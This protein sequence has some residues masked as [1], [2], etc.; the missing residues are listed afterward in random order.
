MA[1]AQLTEQEIAEMRSQRSTPKVADQEA[2]RKKLAAWFARRIEAEGGGE[3]AI[4]SLQVP[5][6]AGMSN[7]TLLFEL[8]WRDADGAQRQRRCVARLQP[9]GQRVVFP[10]YDMSIQYRLM[11]G[12][13]GRVPVPLL[14]GLEEDAAVIGQPFYVMEHVDGLVPPDIPPMHMAGWVRDDTTPAER[15]HMWWIALEAM[16]K[17]HAVSWREDGF[18]FLFARSPGETAQQQ[19]FSYWEHYMRW[20]PEDVP[21]PE[22]ERAFEWFVANNPPDDEEHTGL[23]WGDARLG[24]TMYTPDRREVAAVLD[25]EM[26]MIGDPVQDL[27]WWLFLDRSMSE[28]LG[29][30]RLEGFPGERESIDYW[31]RET[32]RDSSACKYYQAF[33]AFN[34]GLIMIRT[35]LC[36]G[37][38]PLATNFVTP[39]MEKTLAELKG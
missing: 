1:E 12:L 28:G 4:S 34:F 11:D 33:T 20:A 7:I 19:L 36:G 24:N 10:D 14:L 13:K 9:V 2:T 37:M 16:A 23:C 22:Y 25:W 38:D 3:V 8:R 6:T 27:S 18:G 17:V 39:L 30:K 29:I 5:E 26:S 31:A 32:G 15:E 35:S 21:V